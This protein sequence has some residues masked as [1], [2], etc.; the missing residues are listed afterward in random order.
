MAKKLTNEI[1]HALN[2]LAAEFKFLKK[3]DE[4]L[5]NIG[6]EKL[7]QQEKDL[8]KDR[9]VVR[10]IGRAER[11]V[12]GDIKEI[13]QELET[14]KK[15]TLTQE[16]FDD[17][18]KEIEVP[19]HQLLKEGSLYVGNLRKQ[20]N[21]I[22]IDVQLG[23]KYPKK[24][25]R[26]IVQ[27]KIDDLESE[28]QDIEKWIAALDAALKKAASIFDGENIAKALFT[29]ARDSFDR[30]EIE[31]KLKQISTT[32]ENLE[33]STGWNEIKSINGYK[34]QKQKV[35]EVY[36]ILRDT[37]Y[38]LIPIYDEVI[39]EF[40][41]CKDKIDNACEII[42]QKDFKVDDILK[43]RE[44]A[45]ILQ[46]T[47]YLELELLLTSKLWCKSITWDVKMSPQWEF[48]REIIL[49]EKG[50]RY[51]ESARDFAETTRNF[52]TKT[53]KRGISILD[54][55]NFL[56]EKVFALLK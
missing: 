31:K 42:N 34:K 40:K 2:W 1:K 55:I 12:E 26:A 29:L 15:E 4:D 11:R 39:N 20:L 8:K 17:L 30:K 38:S 3:L 16:K 43:L 13:T 7:E 24:E 54:H 18:L 46:H 10:Y 37:I 41:N 25:L 19:A 22:L 51:I 56:F 21:T 23:I 6:K 14:A 50:D 27:K 47:F 49:R 53:A 33:E 45:G 36:P 35:S 52:Y 32:F 28:A 9:R 48:Q 5:G 44:Q